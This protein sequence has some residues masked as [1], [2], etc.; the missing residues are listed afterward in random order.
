MKGTNQDQINAEQSKPQ[1]GLH[2]L[3]QCAK[4]WQMDFNVS[5]CYIQTVT[6]KLDAIQFNH[7]IFGNF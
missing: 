3:G 5:T 7:T 6:T 4:T 1:L 2:A